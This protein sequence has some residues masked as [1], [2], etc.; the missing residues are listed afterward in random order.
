[1]SLLYRRIV[2]FLQLDA[3][4]ED[5]S[6]DQEEEAKTDR[7]EA[8]ACPHGMMDSTQTNPRILRI[9]DRTGFLSKSMDDS[10]C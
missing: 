8:Q 4:A 3:V 1:L 5:L 6:Q 2:F 7:V 9:T 10:S